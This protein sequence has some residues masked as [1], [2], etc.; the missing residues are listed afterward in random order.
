MRLLL[1][2]VIVP[3]VELFLLLR[4]S[5]LTSWWFTFALVVF[6]GI[7]GTA[8]ARAQGFQTLHRIR[9]EMGSGKMPTT[10]V[11]DAAM[12]FG[13]GLLLMTPGILTDIFGFSLLVPFCRLVYRRRILA[14]LKRH[15]QIRTFTNTSQETS[16]PKD[17]VIDSYVID[18]DTTNVDDHS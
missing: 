13:A 11:V 8:L 12:I 4:L 14:W 7:A 1:L 5:E 15:F 17:H 10:S 16:R 6:T 9:S 3:T 2:L 18:K